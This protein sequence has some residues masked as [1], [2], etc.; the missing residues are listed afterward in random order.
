MARSTKDAWLKGPG[1]LATAE[2]EDVP[3]KGESVLVRGLPAAYSNEA[4]SKALKST[5]QGRD[6]VS[7]VDKHELEILQFV[8]GCVEPTFTEAEARQIAEHYGPAWSKVIAKI[9]ELS[10][11]DKE[12]I[13]EANARFQERGATQGRPVVGNG[14]AAGSP[15]SAVPVRA[16]GSAG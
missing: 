3:V 13:D 12:A 11:L 15:E 2:V 14:S 1:D 16:S 9:D 8:H 7:T 4:V 10:G 5:Q 6:T